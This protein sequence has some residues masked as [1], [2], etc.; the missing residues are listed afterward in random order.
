MK[1]HWQTTIKKIIHDKKSTN[2][3]NV[4]KDDLEADEGLIICLLGVGRPDVRC[5]DIPLCC[6]C[7]AR[8]GSRPV[9]I[10]LLGVL[11]LGR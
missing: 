5:G 9:D 10:A 7:W 4:G 3:L 11:A 2:L 1:A 6:C 8:P